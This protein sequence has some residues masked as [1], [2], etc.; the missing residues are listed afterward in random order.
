MENVIVETA[1]VLPKGQITLPK[2]FRDI[3]GVKSGDR[4]VLVSIDGE[5]MMMNPA[6]YAF[7]ALQKKMEGRA[8][9]AGIRDEDDVVKLVRDVRSGGNDG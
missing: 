4:V 5:V 7:K 1:K 3:L 2:D 9:A 6:I 8:E